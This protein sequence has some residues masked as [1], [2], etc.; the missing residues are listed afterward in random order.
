M[1]KKA[2]PSPEE[3]RR[4]GYWW[5]DP[6]QPGA[7]EVAA[8]NKSFAT[9][10]KEKYGIAEAKGKKSMMMHVDGDTWFHWQ[11]KWEIGGKEFLQFY[12]GKR[13]PEDAAY[14]GAE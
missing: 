7:P 12:T 11:W 13:S 3:E 4:F 2:P 9:Y 1:P 8:D 14:W 5:I 10:L 6:N